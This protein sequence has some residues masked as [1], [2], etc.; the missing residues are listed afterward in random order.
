MRNA[1]PRP[2]RRR[3]ILGAVVAA[4]ALS[5]AVPAIA[6]AT[7]EAPAP[8][9]APATAPAPA[10]E[11]A[12]EGHVFA[13]TREADG[14][15]TT[16]SYLPAPGVS[17]TQLHASLRAA[18]VQGLVDP[19][20]SEAAAAPS[21]AYGT[22]RPL[23]GCPPIGWAR[24]GYLNPRIYFRDY[25]APIWPVGR[26]ATKWNESTHVRVERTTRACPGNGTHCVKVVSSDYGTTGWIGL[27][28]YSWDGNRK[29]RDGKV[30]V[31]LNDHYVT[32]ETMGWA[33]ACHELGHAIGL[34]HNTSKSSCMYKQVQIP[35]KKYPLADDYNFI[36]KKLYPR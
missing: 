33:V 35:P 19:A 20:S 23:N 2:L 18:G 8:A 26:A 32:N 11:E 15:V 27:T 24:N 21:C 22:A 34:G 31:K 28:T 4:L 9:T 7:E 5:V 29:F 12:G 16:Q 30:D 17:V 10:A 25:S 6:T 14:S 1:Q 13:V 36:K 3:R